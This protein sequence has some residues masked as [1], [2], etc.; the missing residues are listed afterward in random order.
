MLLIPSLVSYALRIPFYVMYDS[1]SFIGIMHINSLS[2]FIILLIL[3]QLVHTES[4]VG[5]YT[6]DTIVDYL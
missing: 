2:L 6:E 5:G 3:A 4:R 1:Y